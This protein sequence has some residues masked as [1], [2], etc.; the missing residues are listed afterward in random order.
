MRDISAA[1]TGGVISHNTAIG[2]TEITRPIG[3]IGEDHDLV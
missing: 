1:N 3:V 2:I